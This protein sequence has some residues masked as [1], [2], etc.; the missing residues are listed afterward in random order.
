[1]AVEQEFTFG[2]AGFYGYACAG[3]RSQGREDLLKSG[4]VFDFGINI[5][6]E[7]FFDLRYTIDDL[8]FLI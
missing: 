1:M 4:N 3:Y 6:G 2:V 8:R 7:R 5:L